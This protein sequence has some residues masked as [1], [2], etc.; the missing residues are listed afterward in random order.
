MKRISILIACIC[1]FV[2]AR[3]QCDNIYQTW[4]SN[5]FLVTPGSYPLQLNQG[6]IQISGNSLTLSLQNSI[7]WTSASGSSTS[8]KQGEVLEID[9]DCDLPY[10][11]LGLLKNQY[12]SI[13][14]Y[15]VAIDKKKV[16]I[17]CNSG[18]DCSSIAGMG[19]TFTV[20]IPTKNWY[21]DEDGDGFGNA[22]L[23]AIVSWHTP[24]VEFVN[25]NTDCNDN[26]IARNPNTRWY[27]DTDVDGFGDPSIMLTSCEQ[28]IGYITDCLF[29]ECPT[30]SYLE[31]FGC[32]PGTNPTTPTSNENYILTIAPNV[33]AQIIDDA[34]DAIRSIN[35]FDGLGREMQSIAIRQGGDAQDLVTS[36]SYDA[37]GRQNK[38]YLP[39]PAQQASGKYV[40]NAEQ[41]AMDFYG[42]AA[43][44]TT[45]NPY[46]EIEFENTPLN[47][48]LKQAAPGNEWAMG[49]GH[50][51]KFEYQTNAASEVKRFS[52][53]AVWSS[54]KEYYEPTLTN[55]G[56]YDIGQLYKIIIYDENSGPN[57]IDR[58]GSTIEFKDKEGRVVLKRVWGKS[59]H[60]ATTT[61]HD[62]Y[63][64]YDQFGNL[65]YVIPPLA[66]E[67]LSND[68]LNGYGYQYAYDH[69]N[70]L[71]AKKLPGKQWEY[72]AYD[73]L[74]R[75][76]A[77]GPTLDPFGSLD[78]G[79]LIT[80]YDVF[81]R[82]A[83]TG[84]K[85][86]TLTDWPHARVGI[87]NQRS[88]TP[89]FETRDRYGVVQGYTSVSAPTT[90][91]VLTVQHY[92][93]YDYPDAPTPPA[94]V[95]SQTVATN[96]RG[97]A[98]HT[99]N[100]VL[101]DA[102][103][104]NG[105]EAVTFYDTKARVVRT[106][107][108]NFLGGMQN[109]S[110]KLDF[111]GKPLYTITEHQ[112]TAN[113]AVLVITDTLTYT[114]QERPFRHTQTID[115]MDTE[116]LSETHYDALGQLIEKKVGGNATTTWPYQ[117][118][119]YQYNIRGWMTDIND[120]DDLQEDLFAFHINYNQAGTDYPG[121]YTQ[122]PLYNGNISETYWRSASDNVLRQYG[123][124]YDEMNRLR[125]AV[126]IRPETTPSVT[127]AYNETMFYDRNGNIFKLV[128]NGFRDGTDQLPLQVDYLTYLYYTDTNKLRAVEDDTAYTNGFRDGAHT[129]QEYAYDDYGNMTSDANKGISNIIYNHLNLPVIIDFNNGGK[130]LY[131]YDGSGVKLQKTVFDTN[132]QDTETD[133]LS[134]FQ[135][136]NGELLF[137]AT[138]EGYVKRTKS[139]FNYIY[140]YTDHLG[141]NRL[142]YTWDPNDQQLEIMEENNYY[143]FGI[144]HENYNVSRSDFDRDPLGG[145]MVVL[146]P[147]TRLG[148]QYKYNGKE[149][150][151]EL[152][153]NI[154][155][156]DFRQYD[157]AIGR[158]VVTD[159]FAELS[160]SMTPYKFAYNNPIYW[161]DP[162]GLFETKE[163]AKKY[164]REHDIGTGWFSRNKIQQGADGTWAI[165]NAKEG[166]SIFA[167]NAENAAD[168]G[169]E[170][171]EIVTAPLVQSES[172][173]SKESSFGWFTIWGNERSGDTSGLRGTTHESVKSD[174]IPTFS[175]SRARDIKEVGGFLT[176]L[177]SLFTGA[178]D[179]ADLNG[180]AETI[181]SIVKEPGKSTIE[182]QSKEPVIVTKSVKVVEYTF[183]LNDSTVTKN[184]ET[185]TFRGETSV[186]KRQVDSVQ[187]VN[188]GRT[189]DKEAWLRSWG[190]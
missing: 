9:I 59:V 74:D 77:T 170:V 98:T 190:K 166:T 168:L 106:Q 80:K 1:C 120:T 75:V 102:S 42:S 169:V 180:K 16:I 150:Q 33:A 31:N 117:T 52:A 127:D 189:S 137:F 111:T 26:D 95:E 58:D 34:T 118:V 101:D 135:Y 50:E 36:V 146:Q 134:G 130:I 110:T 175:G 64:V 23:P 187:G 115:S 172:K 177:K 156:M 88:N 125:N 173:S 32:M 185:V 163:E 131:L 3:S 76:V 154:T 11:Y 29:D 65:S 5:A 60:D 19:S 116:T 49:N 161:N 8:M 6:S 81:G 105:H 142:S 107:A 149:L 184:T 157:P 73:A 181:Q 158:F 178:K 159:P 171:G 99:W 22:S 82:V 46:S 27:A 92:D 121:D 119:N 124:F 128:R 53:N 55:N 21:P 165:N 70:R 48:V 68:K 152:G 138:S 141:N 91:E 71:A 104:Q 122:K 72:L 56:Y 182:V 83:Y 12:N 20:A 112:R 109:V 108:T 25:N 126:Y 188:R 35:Y 54:A 148:Y 62:T 139:Q 57:P 66:A 43:F 123:Y 41:G 69:R 39:Y 37:L 93:D 78:V 30:I 89:L 18:A 61:P 97:L 129:G 85:A 164:A 87:G 38:T 47:R 143:P 179:V 100:R 133:Y 24:G 44:D 17:Q 167:A 7:Y 144:K 96:V 140:N 145:T 79:W 45:L 113:D 4:D 40:S 90:M 15:S 186:V 153:L 151:D 132:N 14:N 84:W 103:Q 13:T 174:Q 10:M 162:L 147:V 51:I 86:E 136:Q 155:A 160:Y 67:N 63:Y 114:A 183:H 2:E 176:W 94:D 28:P